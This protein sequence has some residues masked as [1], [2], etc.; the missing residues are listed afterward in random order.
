[1]PVTPPPKKSSRSRSRSKSRQRQPIGTDSSTTT[2]NVRSTGRG[3]GKKKPEMTNAP[4]LV[5]T[6]HSH[7]IS[8]VKPKPGLTVALAKQPTIPKA[9]Q[10]LSHLTIDADAPLNAAASEPTVDTTV[11]LNP[12]PM[13]EDSD[14]DL[15]TGDSNVP[16][17]VLYWPQQVRLQVKAEHHPTTRLSLR[18][19]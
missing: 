18:P 17:E 16:L 14:V 2:S 1:M 5:P 12:Q 9:V 10:H 3:R 8:A 13:Y 19:S 15:E 6:T 4:I 11:T 7:L